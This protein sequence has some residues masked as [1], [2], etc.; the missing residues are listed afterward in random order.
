[1]ALENPS[2]APSDDKAVLIL[3]MHRSG[4]SALA[5]SFRDAGL[6][7][8][9]VLGAPISLNP[10]GLQEPASIVH[11]HED[12]LRTNG[13]SWSE[14]PT[15]I[16]WGP[17]HNSVRD[18]F[19]ESRKD[20]GTWGFKEPRTLLVFRGWLQ[21]LP[22]WVGVGIFRD[23]REV[24][25]SMQG[26]NGFDLAKGF[27]IWKIYNN[28]LLSLHRHFD[29]PVIEFTA[30]AEQMRSGISRLVAHVGLCSPAN[31][32]F[33]DALVPR[34]VGLGSDITVPPDVARLLAALREA[35]W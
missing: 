33:Y 12:L 31:P 25:L 14:P 10:K 5:G 32:Q 4:T 2:P 22:N 21:V 29:V 34:H 7:M 35:A 27:E 26:R 28:A 3:G 11:M 15:E 1:M 16:R 30:D 8:G 18:L 19:I 13:G 20:K 9:N 17:L 6:Y 23:P 24:A